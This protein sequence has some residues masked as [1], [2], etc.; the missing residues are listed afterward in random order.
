LTK[1][2]SPHKD[3]LTAIILPENLSSAT[4]PIRKSR[5][6]PPTYRDGYQKSDQYA[7]TDSQRGLTIMLIFEQ[8]WIL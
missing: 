5:G 6:Y 8:A 3:A 4:V 7:S 1:N 2:D